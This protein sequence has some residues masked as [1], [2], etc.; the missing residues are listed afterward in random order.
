VVARGTVEVRPWRIGSDRMRVLALATSYP[1]SPDDSTAPFVRSISRG[2][3]DHGAEVDILLPYHPDLSWPSGDPPVRIHT[4]RYFPGSSTR[5]HVW[6]YAGALKADVS[7]RTGALWMAPLALAATLIRL[8]GLARTLRPHVIHANWVLPNGPPAVMVGRRLGIPVVTSLH[9]S[10]TFLAESGRVLASSAGFALRG[11]AAVTACSGDL[12]RRA[13]RLGARPEQCTVIPYGVD[14][15]AFHPLGPGARAALRDRLGIPPHAVLVLAVGRLVE[16]KGFRY[17][18]EAF[19]R[20]FNES[21]SG[22]GRV[23]SGGERPGSLPDREPPTP[24]LWIAGSG[25]LEADLTERGRRLGLGEGFRLLGN[26]NREGVRELYQ[27][28]DI[29]VVP[30]VHDSAGNVDGLPN[31]LMEGLGSGVAVVASRVAG[32][33]DVLVEGESGLLVREKDPEALA[34]V[35]RLLADAPD[36]RRS[37]GGGARASV[38]ERLNWGVVSGRYFQVLEAAA[39]GE[40]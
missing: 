21:A 29:L 28:A 27:A 17:L 15:E 31:V 23:S 11:S 38:E 20:A 37:L 2:L 6:G 25:D 14:P 10:G 30:S 7:L 16:K 3:A 12:S 24:L 26:V 18:L 34:A 9:G 1:K 39:R 33:P 22:G 35:L 8:A 40:M 19:G 13:Q 36:L 5:R 4:F 32:I